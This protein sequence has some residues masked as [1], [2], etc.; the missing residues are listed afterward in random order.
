MARFIAFLGEKGGSGKS[1]L[2]HLAAHGFGSLPKAIDAVVV[3]TDPSDEVHPI[4]RRYLVVDGRDHGTL[5]TL[6]HRLDHQGDR[7]MVIVD[8]A[9]GRIVVDTAL[10]K[11]ADLILV[12]FT[13]AYSDAVR[14]AK[15]LQRL[16]GAVG[17]PNRWPS[18]PGSKAHANKLLDLLP[19]DRLLDPLATVGKVADL[20]HP[21]EYSRAASSLSRPAQAFAL[22]ILY[23][24]NIHPFDL[25]RHA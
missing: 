1:S 4:P 16:S 14:A 13:P 12:P 6:L 20:L 3:T 11:I 15:H 19:R 23:R 17:V 18:H 21:G 22:E 8:G 2:A 24:M 9:A 7:L 25:R 5:P 10:T